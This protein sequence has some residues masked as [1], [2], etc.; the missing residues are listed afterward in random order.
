V[1]SVTPLLSR[2]EQ[3]IGFASGLGGGS[4]LSGAGLLYGGYEGARRALGGGGPSAAGLAG[5]FITGGPGFMRGGARAGGGVVVGASAAE[6]RALA[7]GGSSYLMPG[8]SSVGSSGLMLAAGGGMLLRSSTAD[9]LGI[10]AARGEVAFNQAYGGVE[11]A[12]YAMPTS[13]GV[14]PLAE[15]GGVAGRLGQVGGAAR[16]AAAGAARIL[17]PLAAIQGILAAASSSGGVPHA[18]NT[19][20]STAASTLTLGTVSPQAIAGVL[21]SA[22]GTDNAGASI[23]SPQLRAIAAQASAVRT[24]G[25]LQQLQGRIE[26]PG[27]ILEMSP[28]DQARVNAFMQH[29]LSVGAANAGGYASNTWEDAF[30]RGIDRGVGPGKAVNTMLKG[31]SS[32]VTALGPRGARAFGGDMAQWA[33]Q[34]EANNP[35]LQR[36]LER[37][38]DG[39]TKRINELD[40]TTGTTFKDLQ[41][42]V[43]YF[44]GQILT[45]SQTTWGKIRDAM[46][47]PAQ[48]A[49]EKLSGIWG[50]I[51]REAINALTQM[52]YSHSQASQI[53]HQLGQGGQAAANANASVAALGATGQHLSPLSTTAPAG[54]PKHERGGMIGGRGLLDTVPVPG[55]M[56]AP[57]EAYIANRHTMNDLTLAT[58]SKF[59]K[60][61]WQ[62]IRD[63]GRPHSAPPRYA[64]GGSMSGG[65]GG[66]GYATYSLP[67]PRGSM[68]PGRWSIDQGVDIPAPAN[69]PEYA[70]GPGVITRAGISGFG[71]NAP[72]LRLTSGPLA[73]QSVYYGHAG[74][75]TVPVGAH[76]SAGQQ[77][78]EVGAGIVG[79]SSGPHIEFGF[80][81]PGTLG[82]GSTMATV[83]HELMSGARVQGVGG[84]AGGASGFM[85]GAI[86]LHAPGT[87]LR[88]VPGAMAH[89]AGAIYATGLQ[90]KIN[91]MT[92]A[93]G[94]S[95][96]GFTGGGSN[97]ANQT[98]GRRMML[99]AGWGMDQWPSLQALWNQES[100]WNAN[101]VNSSSGAYGIPQALGHGHPYNLGDAPAQIAWGLN[102][103][104]GRYGSPAAAEAHERSNNWYSTGGRVN[105]AGWNAKG[106]KFTTMGPTLFGAG[107]KGR[108]TVTIGHGG[109]NGRAIQITMNGVTFYGGDKSQLQGV[110]EEVAGKILEAIDRSEAPSD[111]SLAGAQGG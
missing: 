42:K 54:L 10:G 30:T 103:I 19:G 29:A 89:Q 34:M 69:T 14:V 67:L 108:E 79:I 50:T 58:M 60:T 21:H 20:L 4:L 82:G 68:M 53:V 64:M 17:L 94:I 7:S 61:A 71:P 70:I 92:G 88:G 97:A 3:F 55:G 51:Q 87:G 15:R 5:T 90:A 107:E 59:G 81:P 26:V 91:A 98:L 47:N 93:A 32:Q 75:N 101:A 73:G 36:P 72:V 85:P 45:G 18:I 28:A 63:E 102:Y 6:Q 104:R 46:I 11:G 74:R 65:G 106:G 24:P 16:G 110:A 13:S 84:V 83:L 22:F 43:F 25:Q 49:Q 38:M 31:M 96:A 95:G 80:Y 35:K 109:G 12:R 37:L 33:A 78:S 111:A 100:G 66:A 27:S 99:S 44:N 1:Q 48:V 40:R 62:M 23:S 8:A 105:W 86:S 52:G 56:A 2:A 39:I 9:R 77:I 57:G 41:D 76:V